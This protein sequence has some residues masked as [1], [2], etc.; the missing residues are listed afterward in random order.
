MLWLKIGLFLVILFVSASVVKFALRKL[1]NIEKV[2]KDWFSYNHINKKHKKMDSVVRLATTI[3]L[4]AVAYLVIIKEYSILFY[5]VP[6][7]LLT[8]LDYTVRAFFEWKYT[9]NPKQS[10]VTMGEIITILT[11]T[12]VIVQFDLLHLLS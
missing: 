11:A 5:V 9:E 4:I 3:V 12:A 6:L 10:I 8:V 2:K 1:F 7:V